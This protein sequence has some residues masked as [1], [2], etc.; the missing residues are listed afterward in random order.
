MY[1]DFDSD[2]GSVDEFAFD[3]GACRTELMQNGME[4]VDIE[5]SVREHGSAGGG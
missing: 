1:P 4:Q 2:G 3:R 5:R